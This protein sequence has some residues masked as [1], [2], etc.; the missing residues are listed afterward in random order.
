[1]ETLEMRIHEKIE[2]SHN[3]VADTVSGLGHEFQDIA[4]E[5]KRIADK[6]D[7]IEAEDLKLVIKSYNGITTVKNLITGLATIVI[8]ISAIGAGVIWLIKAA[9]K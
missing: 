5:F 3:S 6:W 2:L 9:I 7:N 1:M 8:S 4:S